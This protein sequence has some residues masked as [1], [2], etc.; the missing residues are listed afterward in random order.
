MKGLKQRL[1]GDLA[2]PKRDKSLEL[3][4][5]NLEKHHEQISLIDQE[6]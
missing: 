5:V 2:I 4:H 6:E 1:Y 3:R